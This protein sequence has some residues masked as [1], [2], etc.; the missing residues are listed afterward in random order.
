MK[1]IVNRELAQY[2][3]EV[4][5]VRHTQNGEKLDKFATRL[6]EFSDAM[7]SLKGAMTAVKVMGGFLLGLTTIILMLLAYLGTH[8]S[9]H[10]AIAI[11]EDTVVSQLQDAVVK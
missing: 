4:G 8:P 5:N 11:H 10:S 3:R 1:V 6:G 9:A 7:S 2:E